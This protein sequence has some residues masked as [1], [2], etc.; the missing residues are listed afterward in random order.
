MALV[1]DPE[2]VHRVPREASIRESYR[3]EREHLGEHVVVTIDVQYGGLVLLGARGDEQ[4]GD[5]DAVATFLP[6]LSM[7]GDC[8]Q[9][10]LVIH[11]QIAER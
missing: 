3:L 5:R 10:R 8:C 7:G 9:D 6:E 1:A 4:I 11:A 2:G